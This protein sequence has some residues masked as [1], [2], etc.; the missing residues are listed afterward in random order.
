METTLL[1]KLFKMREKL[2]FYLNDTKNKIAIRIDIFIYSVLLIN[3]IDHAMM[4][5]DAW[6]EYFH[7]LEKWDTVAFI[8]FF[9]EYCLRV[10]STPIRKK[11]IFSFWGLIDLITVIAL[12]VEIYPNEATWGVVREIRILRFLSLLKYEPATR[13]LVSTFNQIKRELVIFS[14]LTLFLL[15]LSAVGIYFFENPTNSEN[16]PD[17]FHSMW[18]SVATLTTVGYGDI[19][20]ITDGG[21]V[22]STFVVFI[23][24]GIVAVPAGLIAGAFTDI[25]KKNQ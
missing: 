18:W 17:I 14:L 24:L 3:V 5:V 15:Y 22:F 11:F 1:I 19:Y 9:I 25:F 13:N 4:T 8:I 2:N 16:F 10:Y 21:K 7:I 23:G 12:G 6:S 20:P